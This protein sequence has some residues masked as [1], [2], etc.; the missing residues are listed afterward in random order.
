MRRRQPQR[1]RATA[2]GSGSELR[3]QIE[4]AT[5]QPTP[6]EPIKVEPIKVGPA[7]PKSEPRAPA[8]NENSTD[9]T[10]G[11]PLAMRAGQRRA[12]L[13]QA[14]VKVPAD[15]PRARKDIEAALS[16]INALLTGDLEHL[17]S[18]T[19]AEINRWL[20]ASKHLGEN[21]PTVPRS[22]GH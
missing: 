5:P 3:S 17:S 19:A 14:L 20:E 8:H 16:A 4:S 1:S 18:T 13:Q 12:E 2:G 22:V 10:R 15:D 11:E 9:A 21:A 7:P 6:P